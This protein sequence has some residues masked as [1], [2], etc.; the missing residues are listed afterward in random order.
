MDKILLYAEDLSDLAGTTPF[1]ESAFQVYQI[2]GTSIVDSNSD[3]LPLKELLASFSSAMGSICETMQLKSGL[4]MEVLWL[5]FTE[6]TP[7]DI[8]VQD[9]HEIEK[10]SDSFDSLPW[11]IDSPV[12]ELIALRSSIA[13]TLESLVNS[14]GK[15]LGTLKVCQNIH[16]V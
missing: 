9:W 12:E 5:L 14:H 8:S 11:P 7:Y 3:D 4:S 6:N 2:I 15:G 13:Q 16:P 1:D 10:L